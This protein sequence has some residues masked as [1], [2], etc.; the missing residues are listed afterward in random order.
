MRYGW[1]S[2]QRD[3]SSG[4][5]WLG[6]IVNV[7]TAPVRAEIRA[8]SNVVKF[9]QRHWQGIVTG[10]GIVAGVAAA[11]TGVGALAEGS[12]GLGLLSGGLWGPKWSGGPA[13]LHRDRWRS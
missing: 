10:I 3:R 8:A 7:V 11:A 5:G 13:C 12:I 4:L 6:D 9:D 2:R 1:R